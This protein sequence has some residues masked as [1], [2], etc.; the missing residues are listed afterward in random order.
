MQNVAPFGLNCDLFS[1]GATHNGQLGLGET[2]EGWQNMPTQVKLEFKISQIA[3]GAGHC[4]ALTNNR[5][6]FSWGLNVYG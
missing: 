5:K 1:C 6:V 4:V 2:H 3:C